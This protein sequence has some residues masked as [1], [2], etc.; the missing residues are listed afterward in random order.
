MRIIHLIDHLSIG[1]SQ[2]VLYQI[3]KRQQNS[4]I[5]VFILVLHGSEQDVNRYRDIGIKYYILSKKKFNIFLIFKLFKLIKKLKPDLLHQHLIAST[6]MG[7]LLSFIISFKSV[8][9][10]HSVRPLRG[11]MKALFFLYRQCLLKADQ[12]IAVSPSVFKMLQVEFGVLASKLVTIPNF[13]HKGRDRSSLISERKIAREELKI[14][15]E[16][17]LFLNVGSLAW[18]KNVGLLVDAVKRLNSDKCLIYIIGKGSEEKVLKQK[19]KDAGV[20]AQVHF[21]GL[22]EDKL[23]LEQ[24]FLA[25]DV[26]V[27][28]SLIEGMPIVALEAII[29]NS[30]ILSSKVSGV[31]DYFKDHQSALLYEQNDVQGLVEKLNF[32]ME[33][34]ESMKADI[35]NAAFQVYQENFQATECLRSIEEVYKI[36]LK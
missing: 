36:L 32:L 21:L 18:Y 20:D 7:Y 1:G 3:L 14:P 24:L 11:Y 16:V 5:E 15:K 17:T 34:D 22:I 10:I 26:L 23:K 28:T 35:A 2:E 29:H 30:I 31:V 27:I 12:V 13:I 8:I 4:G 19:V 9:H 25:S 33:M 6:C